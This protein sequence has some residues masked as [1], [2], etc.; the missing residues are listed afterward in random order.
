M[1]RIG[2]FLSPIAGLDCISRSGRESRHGGQRPEHRKTAQH[3]SRTFHPGALSGRPSAG[4]P[5]A[6]EHKKSALTA[7]LDLTRNV[8]IVAATGYATFVLWRW[9]WVAAVL[10]CVPVYVVMLNLFGFV[11]LP[12]Y[13]FT[14][15]VRRSRDQEKAILEKPP[16]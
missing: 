4:E 1:D 9:H 3:N 6:S 12:L 5:M 15:E 11:T 7:I 16:N 13:W 10:G 2:N 8:L 14:P